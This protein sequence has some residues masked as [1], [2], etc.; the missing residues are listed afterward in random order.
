MSS[1]SVKYE[2]HVTKSRKWGTRSEIC[3]FLAN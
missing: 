3:Q 1:E 2:E